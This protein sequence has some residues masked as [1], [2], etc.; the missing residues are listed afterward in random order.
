MF[1]LF[2]GDI[3][4]PVWWL[5]KAENADVVFGRVLA[6]VGSHA[7]WDRADTAFIV[8]LIVFLFCGTA[9]LRSSFTYTSRMLCHLN[10]AARYPASK[11]S[12]VQKTYK[13][14]IFWYI[15]YSH[16]KKSISSTPFYLQSMCSHRIF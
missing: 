2:F 14:R 12:N 1:H 9:S 16:K 15:V 5:A 7:T 6:T 11:H 3:Y 10:N 4:L 8:D 13:S